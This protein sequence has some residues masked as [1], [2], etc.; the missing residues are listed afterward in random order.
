VVAWHLPDDRAEWRRVVVP[1]FVLALP[2]GVTELFWTG[3][4]FLYNVVFQQLGDE[5][6]AAAQIVHTLEGV[7]I[8]GSIGLMSATTTLV[9][10]AIGRGDAAGAVE[11][12]DR[13]T[14]GQRGV[15][16]RQGAQHDPRRRG[17]AQRQR[18]ARC[19]HR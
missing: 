9:G 10:R 14:R 7:F 13:L 3:G 12:V 16:G 8:V 19:H 11:W 17:A 18:R 5:A 4:T 15:P 6:L 2:L 1:L